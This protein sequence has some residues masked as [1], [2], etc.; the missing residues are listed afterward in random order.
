MHS[1][2]KYYIKSNNIFKIIP[3]NVTNPAKHNYINN[4]RICP[5]FTILTN[6]YPN[7]NYNHIYNRC[8]DINNYI[9]YRSFYNQSSKRSPSPYD[10]LNV[11][12]DAT[13]KEIKLAYF[14]EGIY[15][16]F[17]SYVLYII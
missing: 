15:L 2:K 11:S 9:K 5:Y 12:K 13:Q 3:N 14:K 7:N 10:L 6:G 8:Y 1:F 4:I 17:T 16:Y